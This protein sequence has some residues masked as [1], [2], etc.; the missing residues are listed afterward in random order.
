MDCS[1][2]AGK[3]NFLQKNK[4]RETLLSSYGYKEQEEFKSQ[5]ITQGG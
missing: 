2:I 5:K 3:P 4:K 1:F